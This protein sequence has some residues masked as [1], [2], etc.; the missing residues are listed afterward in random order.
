MAK[1]C[2]AIRKGRRQGIVYSWDECKDSV[3]GFKGA[4]YKGFDSEQDAYSYLNG[5]DF[6]KPTKTNKTYN[7]DIQA[8]NEGEC[9]LYVDGAY[10]DGVSAFGIYL[11]THNKTYSYSGSVECTEYSNLRNILGE[12][13]G[14]IVG[15]NIVDTNFKVVNIYYDYEGLYKWLTGEFKVKGEMQSKYVRTVLPI[16]TNSKTLYNFKWV[17]GH[18]GIKGN[19]TADRLAKRGL[20]YGSNLDIDALLSGKI[21]IEKLGGI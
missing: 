11:E 14:I 17:K 18:S 21:N 2:Y 9:N 8:P 13:L 15:V 20:T 19:Q 4:E 3:D 1:L 6:H 12:M 5:V 10:R 16:V 7:V